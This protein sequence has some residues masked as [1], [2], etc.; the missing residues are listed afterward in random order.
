MKQIRIISLILFLFMTLILVSANSTNVQASEVTTI[1]TITTEEPVTTQAPITTEA[2]AEVPA[3]EFTKQ[4][5]WLFTILGISV[6]AG[7]GTGIFAVFKVIKQLKR[8]QKE[9]AVNTDETRKTKEVTEKKSQEYK[10]LTKAVLQV[11]TLAP[12]LTYIGKALDSIVTNSQN[13][14]IASQAPDLRD[15]YQKALAAITAAPKEF[16]SIIE[17]VVGAAIREAEKVIEPVKTKT[18]IAD[19]FIK[20]IKE[21]LGA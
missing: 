2:P 13:P 11:Y 20:Q 21:N 1:T 4:F 16:N 12:M 17:D 5:S 8:N 6:P 14:G 19:S 15:S 7:V 9:V 18:E 10:G 3:D